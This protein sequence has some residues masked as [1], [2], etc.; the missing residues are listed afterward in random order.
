MCNVFG[1]EH[2]D[3]VGCRDADPIVVLKNSNADEPRAKTCTCAQGTDCSFED[4]VWVTARRARPTGLALKPTVPGRNDPPP[5]FPCTNLAS[6]VQ[7]AGSIRIGLQ[8]ITSHKAQGGISNRCAFAFLQ[9]CEGERNRKS[10]CF[11]VLS[12]S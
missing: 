12:V 1:R 5:G 4:G 7:T 10:G 3:D 11:I 8:W 9:A 2:K 6:E